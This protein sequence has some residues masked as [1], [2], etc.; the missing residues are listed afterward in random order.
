MLASD[1]LALPITGTTT[2]TPQ[3]RKR[4]DPTNEDDIAQTIKSNGPKE[5]KQS[6]QEY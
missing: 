2:T 5:W 6:D 1:K 3:D 4:P